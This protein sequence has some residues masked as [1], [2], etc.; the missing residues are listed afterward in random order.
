[1]TAVLD[2]FGNGHGYATQVGEA[3]EHLLSLQ[4]HDMARTLVLSLVNQQM[5]QIQQLQH[6]DFA[7]PCRGPDVW[8]D[9]SLALPGTVKIALFVHYVAWQHGTA[10]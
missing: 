9:R 4:Q 10:S 8:H 2:E 7:A 1:M 3:V 5:K 6:P